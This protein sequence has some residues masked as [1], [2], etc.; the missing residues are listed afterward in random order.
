MTEPRTNIHAFAVVGVASDRRGEPSSWVIVKKVVYSREA[1]DAA[2]EPMSHNLRAQG[3]LAQIKQ[4]DPKGA[5]QALVGV[6]PTS[7][8]GRLCEA[9]TQDTAGY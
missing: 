6:R 7:V 5:L 2:D 9:L 4:G 1:A 8:E 3:A